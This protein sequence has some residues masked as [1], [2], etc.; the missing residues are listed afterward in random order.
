[1]IS[2]Y[3]NKLDGRPVETHVTER[4]MTIAR[5]IDANCSK[6]YSAG[7]PLALSVK[8]NDEIVELSDWGSFTFLPSDNVEMRV[9]PKGTD[10]FS[11]TVALFAGVKAVFSMLTPALPGTPSV[12]GQG[13][14]FNESS[15]RGNK[16]KLGDVIRESFGDCKIYPDYLVA[17]RKYFSGPQ[18]Q[19]TEMLLCVGMGEFEI[20]ANNVRIGETPLLSLGDQASYQIFPPGAD[21]SGNSASQNWYTAPEVGSSSTGAAGLELTFSTDITPSAPAQSFL[22]SGYTVTGSFPADWSVGLILR[23]VVPYTYSVADGGGTARDVITGPLGMLNPTVGDAIE[24]VGANEGFYSVNSYTGG[25]SPSM[26]LNFSSGAA[27]NSL[28]TG[29][30]SA[31]IGPRGLRFRITSFSPSS[32]TVERLT[33]GGA[34][35]T[36]FP[37]F[38][39]LTTASATVAV[40]TLSGT[41]GWRGWFL[42]CPENEVTSRIEFD[43][44]M[45]GGLTHVG[46]KGDLNE[47]TVTFEVWYRPFGATGSGVG[48]SFSYTANTLDQFGFSRG[49]DLPS[50]ICPE[51]RVRKTGPAED[52]TQD[53]NTIQWYNLRSKLRAPTSYP[54]VTTIAIKVQSSDRIAAQTE[55]LVWVQAQ[56]KLPLLLNGGWTAPIATRDLAPAALYVA[57]SLQYADSR[58][59]LIEME[60]LGNVW[61]A[62]ADKFDNPYSEER[63]AKDVLNDIFAAGFSEL[64][65][66]QG[67]IRPVRDEPRSQLQFM[68]TPQNMTSN[69]VR[70]PR[71]AANP[72]QFY[73]VDVTFTNRVTWA[74]ETVE[75]RIPGVIGTKVEKVNATGVMSRT[76]AYQYGMRRLRVH[77]YR[78]DSFSWST[79]ADARSA[80]YLSYCA[81]ADDVSGYP[82]SSILRALTRLPGGAYLLQ[83]G[84]PFKWTTGENHMLMLRRPNG[85]ASGPYQA[86]RVD[87]YR[88]TIP[89]LDFIPVVD[90]P[91]LDPTHLLFGIATRYCYPVL[92]TDVS[93]SGLRSAQIEAVGYDAR[94]YLSD[95]STP[96]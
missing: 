96:P 29:S 65:I 8:V 54:G 68:F 88:L 80:R 94:V 69:L 38:V 48:Q 43:M 83:S 25:S 72:D 34:T 44:F 37:G 46:G 3:P 13:K 33:S 61:Q 28:Q 64:T 16:V 45:P 78:T 21:V 10:P 47:R 17:P 95:D 1:M 55:A 57:K 12:P 74:E 89:S 18:A 5:W 35:D 2:I 70:T 53:H 4:R 66:D 51:V 82:Q 6:G 31:A 23:M 15:V 26:T 50:A 73:G 75:C 63:T 56:R 19:W 59:D 93:P 41:G 71:I 90:S 39:A 32:I 79:D 77:Q 7:E 20:F 24:V 67:K 92:I 58:I 49:I 91:S 11:I 36:S 81:A 9:E 42:A 85:T 87:D 84:E 30:G 22:F 27:A 86:T 14:S 76:K 52:G 62:R 60:R 40:D